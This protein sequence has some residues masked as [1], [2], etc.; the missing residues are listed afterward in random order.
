[1]RG[2]AL[3]AAI[4]VAARPA[5]VAAQARPAAAADTARAD[6]VAITLGDAIGRA[7]GQSQEVR[8]A[9]AQVD[10][11]R[12]QV[13]SARSAALPQVNGGLNYTRTFASQFQGGGFSIPD[14]LQFRPDS[15][16][17]IEQR[18]RYIEQNAG[19]AGLGGLG[20][21]FSNLPFGQKNTWSATLTGTQPLF[22]GG[23]VGAGLRIASRYREAAELGLQEQLAD[24]EL[25]VRT[26][27]FQA[28]LAQ[29]LERIA[30]V[31]VA[32]ADSFL[33]QERLRNQAGT[34]S[35]LDVLR[36]EVAAENLRPQLVQARNAASLATLDLKRLIDV[37][38]DRPVR[39]T[40][41]LT[42]PSAQELA[43]PQLDSP[44]LLAQRAAV[45]VAERQV[46]I[47]E[48]QVKI[49]RAGYLPSVDLS[50]SYGKIAFP[51]GVFDFK[52]VDWR[53]DASATVALRVPLFN[54]FRTRA[55]VQEAQVNLLSERLRLTQLQ[56]NVEL[57]YQQAIGEQRR[58]A[59]EITARQRTVE[60]A[61]RV[62]QLT[63][64]R[65]EQGLATQLEVN[66]ARLQAL[67][68]RTNLA[69]SIS[70]FYLASAGVSRSLGVQ[71]VSPTGGTPLQPVPTT[72]ATQQPPVTTPPTTPTPTP[73]TQPA[74]PTPPPTPPTAP[75]AP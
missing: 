72:P 29:E 13:T 31:S 61:Q 75:T 64:L 18:L 44:R 26:A 47:R 19:L 21:L 51:P 71:Q 59:A 25:Q 23:R 37:P 65:Y 42:V 66:D 63:V 27:Y 46:A 7:V 53:T 45:R 55:D 67:Q 3:V 57:Q 58:A 34:A 68:A 69:Q 32:Q 20:A 41:P 33:A 48:E 43:D 52:G 6:S 10:L 1:M 16:A 4:A 70:S 2:A 39:L 24:I 14:S 38:L 22:S 17:S 15:T 49:A 74:R 8:L 30:Q 12:A 5:T 73:T 62:Y 60:Q 54:G 11:A 40:T 28:L 35:D 56:E 50:G 9:R 36:A